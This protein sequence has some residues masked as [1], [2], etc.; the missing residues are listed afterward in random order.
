MGHDGPP[1]GRAVDGG[2]PV[3][4]R[5]P[6]E[7]GRI[8]GDSGER[9]LT[10]REALEVRSDRTRRVISSF[11]R[12]GDGPSTVK[13]GILPGLLPGI[14]IALVCVLVVGIGSVASTAMAGSSAAP[15]GSALASVSPGSTSIA[16]APT[17][18]SSSSAAASS[19]PSVAP[20]STGGLGK[21]P[22]IPA[23]ISSLSVTFL[24][25]TTTQGWTAR[26]TSASGSTFTGS[27]DATFGRSSGGSLMVTTTGQ[28]TSSIATGTWSWTGSWADL[29]IPSGKTVVSLT[30]AFD[31][32]LDK[33]TGGGVSAVHTSMD[34]GD[35]AG[36][37]VARVVPPADD[38]TAG[39]WV[40]S[41]GSSFA[42]P[43][44]YQPSTTKIT[45]LLNGQTGGLGGATWHLDNIK[46]TIAFA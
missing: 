38:P 29:C 26:S 40:T 35:A 25:P 7:R 12:I 5:D 10:D 6:S 37:V 23:G 43:A 33:L 18:A 3:I 32:Y 46:L 42:V 13:P 31:V 4:G 14:A 1:P 44:A 9:E 28:T 39:A 11:M 19:G 20:T 2:Q 30:S 41:T 16:V 22:Q 24:F 15:S 8:E 21:C 34:L 36:T 27:Y 45:L 17:P